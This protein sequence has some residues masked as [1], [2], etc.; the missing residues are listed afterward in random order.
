MSKKKRNAIL[1]ALVALAVT[2]TMMVSDNTVYAATATNTDLVKVNDD[3]NTTASDTATATGA[4]AIAIGD[5]AAASND[6]AIAIGSAQ[7]RQELIVDADGNPILD[8]DGNE[9]YRVVYTPTTASGPGNSIAIGTGA[10]ADTNGTYSSGLGTAIAIG[11]GASAKAPGG[12]S[13]AIGGNAKAEYRDT[14]AIGDAA[15]FGWGTGGESFDGS[16]SVAIG[17]A[18]VNG[19]NS[20]AIGYS[21]S[22]GVASTSDSG[23]NYESNDS[24]AIL[25][26]TWYNNS[27]ALGGDAGDTTEGNAIAIG[28]DSRAYG[29]SVVIGANSGSK[30][31]GQSLDTEGYYASVSIGSGAQA[32][33]RSVALGYESST[34]TRGVA[35]GYQATS[36]GHGAI[37]IGGAATYD[38]HNDS[39]GYSSLAVTTAS[40][41]YAVALGSGSNADQEGSVALGSYSQT[42]EANTVESTIVINGTTYNVGTAGTTDTL[43]TVSVGGECNDGGGSKTIYRQI[44]NVAAGQVSDTST[45]AV[46]GSQLY[47]AYQAV[48][49]VTVDVNTIVGVDITDSSALTTA[50]TGTNY[51]SNATS[52]VNADIKLDA[53]IK[54]NTDAIATNAEEIAKKADADSVYTKT[55]ADAL[56][57]NKA[58][59][60]YVDD[61]LAKKANTADVTTALAGKADAD[62]VYT[63]TEADGK[64]A[65][66]ETVNAILGTDDGSAPTTSLT[67]VS[68]KVTNI[69]YNSTSGTTTIKG[70]LSTETITANTITT[71]TITTNT[72]TTETI[73]T[74]GDASLANGALT[75]DADTGDVTVKGDIDIANGGLK[76]TT[77]ATTGKTDVTVTGDITAGGDVVATNG[78]ETV[79]LI[80]T[81][82]KVDTLES[83]VTTLEKNVSEDLSDLKGRVTTAEGEI[84]TLQAT[85]AGITRTTTEQ[86]ATTD[87]TTVTDKL[88]AANGISM[89]SD[90]GTGTFTVNKVGENTMMY[91]NDADKG[92]LYAVDASNGNVSTQGSLVA[93]AVYDDNYNLTDYGFMANENGATINGVSTVNGDQNISG[94]LKAG[95]IT[96]ADGNVTGHAFEA[97]NQ[98]AKVNGNLQISAQEGVEGT[99]NLGVEGGITAGTDVV[100]QGHSL[101][102]TSKQATAN[103]EAIGDRQ[104]TSTNYIAAGDSLTTAAGKLDAQVKTNADAIKTNADNIGDMNFADTNYVSDA[105]TLTSAVTTLDTQVKTNADGIATNATNIATNKTNIETNTTNIA[106]NAANIAANTTAIDE[107]R[108]AIIG[109]GQDLSSLGNRMDK[110]GAG[111]AALAALHPLDYD[112]ENKL[113]FSAGIGN[114]AGATAGAVGAFYRPN[115][116]VMFSIGG[117]M[118]N[119]E[120]MVNA[121][122]SF[123]LGKGGQFAKMSKVELIQEV[124]A[125]KEE[126]KELKAENREIRHELNKLKAL[127]LE[128][129]EKQQ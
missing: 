87:T 98:G 85:T 90:G 96:D 21:A 8:T 33:G 108:N 45:D 37:A 65:T 23:I 49:D 11:D 82:E 124:S 4:G 1:S 106:T 95:A 100:A 63:K 115:E 112:S 10:T 123:A 88:V 59:K 71:E 107:N 34:S 60:S 16:G 93:G 81:A 54:A 22:A 125:V 19:K 91:V 48:N 17:Y 40:G 99:G 25:G 75:A 104:Y 128:L 30:Y 2:G 7:A 119:G 53:Q 31:E 58:D 69:T 55:E 76:T 32:E 44:Q 111:A 66:Q 36:S 129:A 51:I 43:Y 64:F 12:T 56:L 9:Q 67:E 47:A 6:N 73:T 39:S 52:L 41:R 3:S 89:S 5:S 116:D 97:N 127:V 18:N 121:G 20:V 72:I 74:T 42:E 92:L 35:L 27:I 61:E 50:Y 113:S 84:D 110:V 78:N 28:K 86:G 122:V 94:G 109:L 24:I 70:T 26:T 79:S 38:T 68:E 29:Y 101:V 126:N 62:S 105:K 83:K 114:Y 77:D 102:E 120:N 103:K 15:I 14:V 46:N 117:T 57:G 118:G 13:V 80:E